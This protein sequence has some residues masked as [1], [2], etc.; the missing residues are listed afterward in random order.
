MSMRMRLTLLLSHVVPIQDLREAEK[1]ALVAKRITFQEVF[2]RASQ[3]PAA[4]PLLWDYAPI[5]TIYTTT[6]W[7]DAPR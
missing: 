7:Q 5:N 1:A 6:G 4:P 2:A 3:E